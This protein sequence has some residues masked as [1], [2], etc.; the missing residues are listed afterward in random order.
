MNKTILIVDDEVKILE[1]IEAYLKAEGFR[2][3]K[4]TDGKEA[5]AIFREEQ[6]DFIVLDLMLPEIDGYAVAREI[7]KVSE[8]PIIMLTARSAEQDILGGLSLGAD[9]YLVKP[10]RPKEL[11]AR[12]YAV[13]RRTGSDSVRDV[14]S[15]NNGELEIHLDSQRVF[16]RGDE[17]QLTST[18]FEIL[19]TLAL[20]PN[21]LF[22]RNDLISRVLGEDFDGYDRT[23]DSH[24]KN[25]RHKIEALPKEPQYVLTVHGTGYRFGSFK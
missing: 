6:P 4:A 23:V 20:N 21:K 10:F 14:L 7:R 12:I 3:L 13:L 1:F 25:L 22:T 19:K 5:L 18:E 17:V 16:V 24:I 9:D 8:V 2:V 11:V 15:I